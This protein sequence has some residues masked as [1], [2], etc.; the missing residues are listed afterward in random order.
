GQCR[1]STPWQ[2]HEYE[3]G[4]SALDKTEMERAS[5]P[6]DFPGKEYP[7]AVRCEQLWWQK[8]R[9]RLIRVV[10]GR[11]EFGRYRARVIVGQLLNLLGGERQPADDSGQTNLQCALLRRAIV[12]SGSIDGIRIG[13]PVENRP[14]IVLEHGS[15]E[16][17]V[18]ELVAVLRQEFIEEGH[19]VLVVLANEQELALRPEERVEFILA[20]AVSL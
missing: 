4:G 12:G 8:R 13:Q 18:D 19:D 17:I 3:E 5:G 7:G 9:F 2:V 1:L 14:E 20:V 6:P 16:R 10:A 11:K 15:L